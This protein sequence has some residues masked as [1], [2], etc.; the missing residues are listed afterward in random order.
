MTIGLDESER[1]FLILACALVA[2][3]RPGWDYCSG[4]IADKLQGK[5]MFERMKELNADVVKP[6]E[7]RR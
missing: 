1:Q 2:L 6:Q 5:A 4:T 3:L 7:V